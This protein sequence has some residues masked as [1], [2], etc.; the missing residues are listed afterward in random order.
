MPRSDSLVIRV[1]LTALVAFGPLS[2]DLYLPALPS[3]VAIFGTD[4]ATVQLTLSVFLVGFAVS[5]L[6]YGPVSDRFG[7]RPALI[8]GILVYLVASVACVFA[9]GIGQLIVARFFQA[10]GAC[11][12]PVVARAVVRDVFGR[13][14]AATVLAYM[15]MAMTLAPAVGPVLGGALTQAFGW[16]AN[17]VALVAVAGAVLT[18]TLLLLGETNTHR[19]A[20]ALRPSR[21]LTN[22]LRLFR[23]RGFGGHALTS[24]CTYS[25]IFAFISGSSFVL[26]ERVGLSPAAYGFSFAV[27]VA[28]YTAGSF[29]AG[30]LTPRVG[31]H[32]MVRLG[33]AISVAGGLVG[34]GL[35][36]GGVV[37]VPAIVLP[38]FVFNVGAGL[39]LPN[40]MAGAVGP[41]PT[42]AG[43][44]SALLGFAQMGVAAAVG[45]LVG[46]LHDGTSRPMMGAVALVALGAAAAYRLLV[47][48]AALDR[49]H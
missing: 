28:G 25:G 18:A 40:A 31:G 21:L 27:V 2:T 17:F 46:H 38:L 44:A 35:A 23:D 1:L 26:I 41:Y 39:T 48:P 37:T 43:L 10:V 45:I 15:S 16:R 34:A 3:L 4:I 47:I 36:W 24:A 49:F 7:R 33:T 30:R 42:M 5:Q 20:E 8:G 14:R 6:V 13:D 12:G 11:C 32:R 9:D 22:Y 19:D 29:L